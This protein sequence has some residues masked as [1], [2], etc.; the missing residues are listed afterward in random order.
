MSETKVNIGQDAR[1]EIVW[2]VLSVNYTEDKEKD[3]KTVF[4][5]KYGIPASH[6]TVTPNFISNNDGDTVSLNSD[7]IQN[8][9]DPKFQQALFPECLKE[10]GID[11]YDLD[12]LIKI[13]SQ[14]NALIDY[15]SYEKG[16][17]YTLKWLDWSNFLAY[18]PSN[19]F[20]FTQLSGLTL[21]N[22]VPA[23]QGGKSTFAYDLL[24]FLFFGR[25]SSGK[26]DVLENLFNNH[27]VN[28]TELKV[29]GCINIDGED[30]I[31][32][33]TLTRPAASRKS[34]PVTQKV[35]YFR[36]MPDGSTVELADND[37]LNEGSN[38]KTSQA[39]KE[40]IGN[41][42][43]FDLVISANSDNLK[44]LIAL[45]KT[46]RGRLLT[47]WIGLL[48]LE[49]K[50][51]KAREKWNREISVNRFCDKYNTETLKSEI[52]NLET[53]IKDA[54]T[55]IEKNKGIIAECDNK[56][57]DYNTTKETL[58]ASKKEIKN[59][60]FSV[61][62]VTLEERIKRLIETGKQ[63]AAE[64]EKYETQLNAI[65]E[66]D[67]NLLITEDDYKNKLKEKEEI[68]TKIANI[69]NKISNLKTTNKNLKESEFC[70][71]CKRK[72]EN[73]D[74]SATIAENEAE[75]QKLIQLGISTN[76]T[77]N[78]IEANLTK[79]DAERAKLTERNR[80]EL[81]IAKLDVEIANKR[82]EYKEKKQLQKEINDN[83][84]A[85]ENNN[86]IDTALNVVNYNIKTEESIKNTANIRIVSF[87]GDI[88]D[89]KQQIIDKKV[90]IQKIEEEQKIEKNWKTYLMLIGKD[91][92]SKMVLRNALPIINSELKRFLEGVCDFN[93]EVE[94]N[95]K[96]D[97][98]FTLICKDDN[99]RQRLAAGSGFEQTAA[100]LAL[101]VVLGNMSSLSKPPF[102]FLDEVLGNVADENY[103]SMKL[104]YDKIA[105][106][107]AFVL[108]V[109]HNKQV[110][111]WH[112]K[113]IT[114]VK[115]NHVSHIEVKQ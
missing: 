24:H 5:K 66:I 102:L 114:V 95:E 79:I 19:H 76:A 12:E 45:K 16:R 7:T 64:K 47:R 106:N 86:K 20:D 32:K 68:I 70:P 28:E 30:Y 97:V 33:R 67:M 34:R 57:K 52:Q 105:Q 55:Q 18:G 87:E 2:N 92:I 100:A 107:F 75:I 35:E 62:V 108:Q 3:I 69:K 27:L 23:N 89:Y 46:D 72:F 53:Q 39:I 71:L 8:I 61:D 63:R 111:E 103:D 1:V 104:L 54:Q 60:L 74:N 42:R 84:A 113:T 80:F 22:S 51:I 78:E 50:D 65:G 99:V 90:I 88:K 58:L 44:E 31:I 38:V 93:V 37:N 41:E 109:T 96:N 115:K 4:A 11:D 6:I 29:E 91:G 13:D 40:A 21:L 56:I 98:D 73:V 112:N 77:K 81:L 48:P 110:Y 59:E 85:I 83:K 49:D 82:T 43:D 17:K 36:L 14:M 94:I 25:T 10:H 9:H 26:A 15:D 101:R